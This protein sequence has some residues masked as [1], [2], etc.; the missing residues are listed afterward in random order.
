MRRLG[1][2]G[3]DLSEAEEN[4][5]DLLKFSLLAEQFSWSLRAPVWEPGVFLPWRDGVCGRGLEREL[6]VSESLARISLTRVFTTI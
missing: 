2:P 1:I 4:R 5:E 3:R 6:S